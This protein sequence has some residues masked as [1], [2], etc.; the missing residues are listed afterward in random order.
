MPNY[1]YVSGRKSQ[2][3]LGVPSY[4]DNR[5]VL[6]VTSGKVGI[7]TTEAFANAKLD[8]IGGTRLAGSL[9]D[10]TSSPGSNT[11]VLSSTGSGLLWV[12][13]SDPN[14][15]IGITIQEEGATVG[16]AASVQTI[17]FVGNNISA[18]ASGTIATVTVDPFD[19]AGE[20]GQIQF[21]DGG[22]F[23]GSTAFYYNK[24]LA[25]VSIGKSTQNQTFD[26]EGSGDFSGDLYA[27][28]IFVDQIS[29]SQQNELATK[30]YVDFFATA[31]IVIQQ[32]VAAAT[33]ANIGFV[34]YI[35]GPNAG[36][37]SS[38]LG[39]GAALSAT[40]NGILVIDSYSPIVGDRIL[41]KNQILAQHNGYYGVASTGSASSKWLLTRQS[42]FDEPDEI[43]EGAFSFVTN[44]EV[45]GANGFVLIE[46]DPPFESGGYVGFSSLNFTQFSA[47]GQVNAGDGLF[48]VENTVNVGTASS[49]RIVVNANDIDLANV[50]TTDTFVNSGDTRFVT[51]VI[52]DGYGR[53][54][55]ITS[56]RHSFAT[57]STAGIAAFESTDFYIGSNGLVGLGSNLQLGGTSQMQVGILTA[58]QIFG[59]INSLATGIGNI[60][61]GIVTAQFFYGNGSNLTGI[62]A[63]VGLQTAGGY[64]GSGATILDFRGAGVG[65]VS[66]NITSG[67]GTITITGG[68]DVNSIGSANQVLY[69]NSSNLAAGS[70]NLTFNGTNLVCGGTVTANS[71]MRIK[72]NVKKIN[73]ALEKVSSL[74]GVEFD[75]T[76]ISDHQIGLIAQEVEEV[77]P[78]V[79]YE[80]GG[81]KSIAYGNLVGLL[82]ESIKQLNE[83]NNHLEMRIKD[84]EQNK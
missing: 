72:K 36:I 16:T 40:T 53:V 44:G 70:A 3:K 22:A 4:S 42:D 11:Q 32:A 68:T 41:V 47:P 20:N 7:G 60:N 26:V 52:T 5:T 65:Q 33:T 62:T 75:R 63:G 57:Y 17:N 78:E 21:N 38:T 64:V 56:D 61:A 51:K 9:Y 37:G 13:A 77:I 45:N 83:K 25:R 71:D 35:N 2:I 28:R 39:V 24:T 55:G 59:T 80:N 67:I 48:K 74:R 31:A 54:T 79:V 10:G 66:L 58:T 6:E 15:I 12:D 81:L 82:I 50:T 8:V 1:E 19:A 49:S 46:V 34:T 76:D 14:S 43:T 27:N 84:L 73:N 18:T 30:E 29:P 23:A 69:K